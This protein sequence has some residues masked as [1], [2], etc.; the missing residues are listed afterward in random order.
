MMPRVHILHTCFTL[1]KNRSFRAIKSRV[2]A[3]F[4]LKNVIFFFQGPGFITNITLSVTPDLPKKS[5][6]SEGANFGAS[7]CMYV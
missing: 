3:M 7:V 1:L 2:N 6:L 4:Q 5:F